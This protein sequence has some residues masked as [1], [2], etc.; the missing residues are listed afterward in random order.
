ML[1]VTYECRSY[2]TEYNVGLLQHFVP[3]LLVHFE[4]ESSVD[5]SVSVLRSRHDLKHDLFTVVHLWTCPTVRVL[6]LLCTSTTGMISS[7]TDVLVLGSAPLR[8]TG[9]PVVLPQEKKK[10]F[11]NREDYFIK[12]NITNKDNHF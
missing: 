1:N 3:V 10:P 9:G 11:F 5:V 8:K 6:V 2:A 7:G 4:Q 12:T